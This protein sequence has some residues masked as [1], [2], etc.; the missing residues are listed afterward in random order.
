MSKSMLGVKL[1]RG[2]IVVLS[3]DGTLVY[4]EDV[5]PTHCAVVAL[6]EQPPGRRVDAVFT[7]GK[8]GA[9][10]ISPYAGYDREIAVSELS[11]RNREFIGT[12]ETLR[13]Q[14]G[15]NYVQRTPEEEKA[16]SVIKAGPAPRER[17]KRSPEDKKNKRAERRANNVICVKC[18]K[19]RKHADHA[20]NTCTFEAP[21]EKVKRACAEAAPAAA[22]GPAR[23][24]VVSTDL[25]K[26]QEASDKFKDGNRFWRV[27]RALNGLPEST[28]AME[29]IVR[30][31][32]L[33]GGRE[34]SDVEKV[35]RRALK[36]LQDAGNVVRA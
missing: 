24:R 3:L 18:G 20:F 28:G 25:T 29:D 1:Q 33:D 21:P 13:T 6:P 26:A 7:P 19:A 35:T 34:M 8:V 30:A 36:G 27:F 2:T 22:A 23:Y 16:M 14:H 5:Q 17:K 10:K 15:P 4:V 12:Y 31:V 9:K 11:D 32:V